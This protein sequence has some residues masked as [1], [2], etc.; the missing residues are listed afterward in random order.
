MT[1]LEVLD[2]AFPMY[3]GYS[4]EKADRGLAIAR[5]NYQNRMAVAERTGRIPDQGYDAFF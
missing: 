1:P 3:P 5:R 2:L 4:E